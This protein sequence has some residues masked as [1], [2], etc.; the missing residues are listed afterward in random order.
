MS[1]I[2]AKAERALRL[3]RDAAPHIKARE[4]C[5]LLGELAREW[6]REHPED[7]GELGVGGGVMGALSD[8]PKPDYLRP[9]AIRERSRLIREAK[10][11]LKE[12]KINRN[13]SYQDDDMSSVRERVQRPKRDG[14]FSVGD[15][16]RMPHYEA[17]GGYRVWHVVG[18]HLGGTF[19]EG[20]YHLRCV[21][22]HENE[23][24]HVPCIILD[25]HPEI[26]RL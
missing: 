24:I 8:F 12:M 25:T 9:E 13:P 17:T 7:D 26:E 20:T 1:D 23:V 5:Q 14:G 4:Q 10:K 19:Q 2:R 11:V 18:V 16:V 22:I 6:L 15:T 3:Y 21:D